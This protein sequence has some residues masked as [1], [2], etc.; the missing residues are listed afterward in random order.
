MQRIK[1]NLYILY[2]K[3]KNSNFNPRIFPTQ[4]PSETIRT[5]IKGYRASQAKRIH[6]KHLYDIVAKMV[7][8]TKKIYALSFK[9]AVKKRNKQ[10]DVIISQITNTQTLISQMR[11]KIEKKSR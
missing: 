1:H 11:V 7:S 3:L 2:T 4:S 6:K 9:C 8:N 5:P 10:L